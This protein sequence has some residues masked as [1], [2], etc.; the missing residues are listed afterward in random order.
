MTQSE[1]ENAPSPAAATDPGR[2][3][4]AGPEAAGAIDP[5]HPEAAPQGGAAP[6]HPVLT[7]ASAPAEA[8]SDAGAS[9]AGA[10]DEGASDDEAPN[11]GAAN[12]GADGT[13]DGGGAGEG[14]TPPQPT[15]DE[16]ARV[17][18]LFD[19]AE[20]ADA[21]LTGFHFARWTRPLCPAV[22]GADAAGA[23]AMV[24]GLRDAA[25]LVG[26][27]VVDEDPDFGANILYFFCEDWADLRKAPGLDR[28]IPD[29]DKLTVLLA[30]AGAN[31]YRIFSFSPDR[32]LRLAVVL[33][34]Y[35]DDLGRLS[36]QALALGQ[37]VQTLLLWSDRAFVRENP[38]DL[39]FRRGRAHRDRRPRVT[40]WFAALLRAAY[41]EDAPA[42]ATDPALAET[43]AAAVIAELDAP[44]PRRRGASDDGP[45]AKAAAEPDAE[46][47]AEPAAE[48]GAPSDAT[49]G[50]EPGATSGSELAE[51]GGA[52][53]P[54][55][56]AAAVSEAATGAD[57]AS[58]PAAR[59]A[60][61]PIEPGGPASGDPQN[62][63]EQAEEPMDD[64]ARAPEA[65]AP[66]PRVE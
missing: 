45:A 26:L 15:P 36:P 4:E 48:T 57:A 61:E 2:P 53:R 34:R 39:G 18:D 58:G 59:P 30:A 29:L 31:Q 6:T 19:R 16:V 25:K 1:P 22:F 35:D 42:Y 24:S 37:A 27:E 8:T 3:I 5:A 13:A 38:V 54:P 51:A 63:A 23:E 44:S 46:P 56:D 65:S 47:G 28:L 20:S 64:G 50:S 60:Q 17:R 41:A 21:P 62:V 55:S 32:G 12:D 49:S 52:D 9:D 11:D 10:S 40:R 66:T 7:V 14:G 33:L 43:L